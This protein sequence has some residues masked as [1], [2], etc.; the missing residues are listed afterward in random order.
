MHP[1]IFQDG[2]F[3][4]DEPRPWPAFALALTGCFVVLLLALAEYRDHHQPIPPLTKTVVEKVPF[5]EQGNRVWRVRAEDGTVADVPFDIFVTLDPAEKY[6]TPNWKAP[7]A[8][9]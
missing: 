6:A 1:D 5:D 9:R 2:R 4:H 7:T 8:E 3:K